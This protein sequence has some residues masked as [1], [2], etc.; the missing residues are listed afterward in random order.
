[1]PDPYPAMRP[2]K[3]AGRPSCLVM[4]PQNARASETRRARL[5]AAFDALDCNERAD[6]LEML[7][8]LSH[9]GFTEPWKQDVRGL[10]AKIYKLAGLR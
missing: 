7:E 3:N 6:L 1:M 9:A 8:T 2:S 5:L 10:F 4:N